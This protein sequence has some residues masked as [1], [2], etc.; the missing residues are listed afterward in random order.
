MQH[1]KYRSAAVVKV[2]DSQV[3]SE[4]VQGWA[5]GYGVPLAYFYADN[6]DLAEVI[7]A[8]GL[9][10]EPEQRRLALELKARVSSPAMKPRPA[11]SA[12]AARRAR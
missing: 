9:L 10:P 8:F 4:M 5:N 1:Q 12:Q 6:G 3:E 2:K 7:L 11:R